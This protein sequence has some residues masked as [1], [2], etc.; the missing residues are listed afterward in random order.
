MGVV[1]TMRSLASFA[2]AASLAWS[3]S[4]VA[5]PSSNVAWTP[6]LK[7]LVD[8][9]DAARGQQLEAV[10]TEDVAACTECHGEA[11]AEA[12]REKWPMLAGQVAAYTFKQLQDYKD[13]KR[14]HK[15]MAGA[16]EGLSSQDLADLSAWYA[17][18]P[19]PQPEVDADDE[20]SRETIRLVYKGDKKRL[21][22]PCA[23][24]H[25]R[26]GEGA[27]ID[28]PS[29]TGQNVKYFVD[30]MKKYAKEKRSNDIYGRMRIIAKA[31]SKD[32][33]EELAVYYARLGSK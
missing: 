18:R 14:K 27:V 30:T 28:V 31:L 11:G 5:E 26:K 7:R 16:V 25:G 4:A 13:G 23:S 1:K 6:E 32:E 24:C 33:I 17:S 21:I 20:V 19:L 10:E 2:L 12:G 8:R 15:K 3:G 29:I 22:Q 9:G